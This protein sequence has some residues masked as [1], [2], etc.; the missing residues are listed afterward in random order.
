MKTE[1]EIYALLTETTLMLKE[2]VKEARS[3]TT[4]SNI[5]DC[6]TAAGIIEGYCAVLEINYRTYIEDNLSA[7]DAEF[8]RKIKFKESSKK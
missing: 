4:L 3:Q 1:K 2:L 5:G 6:R 7:E 8:L